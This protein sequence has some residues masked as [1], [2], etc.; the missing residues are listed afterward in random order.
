MSSLRGGPPALKQL[1]RACRYANTAN[2]PPAISR[3]LEGPHGRS[4]RQIALSRASPSDGGAPEPKTRKKRPQ[5]TFSV[6]YETGSLHGAS[7][8]GIAV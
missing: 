4:T 2:L 1:H 3:V 5:S 8:R 7:S 6:R